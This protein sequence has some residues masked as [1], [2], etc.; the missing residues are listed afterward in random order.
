MSK[1]RQFTK[2]CSQYSFSLVS[3]LNYI[4]FFGERSLHL[5]E[6]CLCY[7]K[8]GLNFTRKSCIICYHATHVVLNS[9]DLRSKH[10]NK[11]FFLHTKFKF[12]MTSIW[13]FSSFHASNRNK[14]ILGNWNPNVGGVGGRSRQ[15]QV[16]YHWISKLLTNIRVY[17][18]DF[19]RRLL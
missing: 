16:S 15:A 19:Y 8:T 5:A 7:G 6:C 14:C 3:S 2:P 12:N 18:T 4:L 1:F 13:N 17:Q 11:L 9:I 10:C